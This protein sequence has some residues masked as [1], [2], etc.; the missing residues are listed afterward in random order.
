M[1]DSARSYSDRDIEVHTDKNT[2]IVKKL[3]FIHC[4]IGKYIF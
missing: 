4:R 3:I 2:D 1:R